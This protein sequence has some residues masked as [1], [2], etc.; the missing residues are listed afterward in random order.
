MY[1]YPKEQ[2]PQKLYELFFDDER[3]DAFGVAFGFKNALLFNCL[4]VIIRGVKQSDK[5]DYDKK[6]DLCKNLLD[7][8]SNLS[9]DIAFSNDSV[10]C[11]NLIGFFCEQLNL[12]RTNFEK[13]IFRFGYQVFKYMKQEKIQK[14]I[15][16]DEKN[17]IWL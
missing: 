1:K 8:F 10:S 17:L 3:F 5:Y 9:Y 4:D 7:A 12:N 2:I 15:N 6:R 14:F 16:F 11:E 13:L